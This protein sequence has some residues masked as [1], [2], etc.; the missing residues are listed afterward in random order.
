M[1]VYR[2]NSN[3]VV[4]R[5]GDSCI[6]IFS[7]FLFI[8][9]FIAFPKAWCWQRDLL[10][11]KFHFYSVVF[12]FSKVLSKVVKSIAFYSTW[13]AGR[14]AL[15]VR[16]K[17]PGKT[18]NGMSARMASFVGVLVHLSLYIS[19]QWPHS[20]LSFPPLSEIRNVN[21]FYLM[22]FLLSHSPIWNPFVNV[23][24]VFGRVNSVSLGKHCCSL[25]CWWCWWWWWIAWMG[26]HLHGPALCF[27]VLK[28]LSL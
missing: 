5:D 9:L 26:I 12:Y 19:L 13:N 27:T 24:R 10:W 8:Y 4:W 7:H 18:A 1:A 3:E 11:C 20:H 6:E 15:G 2:S 17:L 14:R 23:I 28:V 25:H 21:G 16:H 22:F